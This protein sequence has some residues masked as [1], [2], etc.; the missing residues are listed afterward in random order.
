[1]RSRRRQLSSLLAAFVLVLLGAAWMLLA[2]AQ[3]GG[4]LTYVIVTGNSMEPTL[5]YGDLALVRAAPSYQVGDVVLYRHPEVGTVI[6]R[7]IGRDGDRF[8]FKGD[9]NSWTDS[10]Q[11]SRDA[12]IGALWIHLPA[13]GQ[14]VGQL[15]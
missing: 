13:A 2:P 14:V 7:I 4:R 9:H 10:Y 6:H 5:H 1:M 8:I 3:L 11:P 15:R 12:L